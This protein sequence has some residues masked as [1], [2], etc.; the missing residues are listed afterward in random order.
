M[1]C[2]VEEYIARSTI[3]IEPKMPEQSRERNGL[4]VDNSIELTSFNLDLA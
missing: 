3:T 4:V 2:L 1:S